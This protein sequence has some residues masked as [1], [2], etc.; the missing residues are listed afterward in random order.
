MKLQL[1][2][3]ND[4]FSDPKYQTEECRQLL[5]IYKDYY[6]KKGFQPP[7]VAYLILNDKN[8]MG[9]CSFTE[10]PINGAVEIAYWTFK[11]FEGKGVAS[12]A[13]ESLIHIAEKADPNVLL[14]AKTAPE[15]NASTRILEKNG[16][17]FSGVVQDDEIGDAWLWKKNN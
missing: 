7:W 14:T 9:T 15:H 13:C 2:N 5:E 1:L 11:P 8:V 10:K 6:S 12:F 3:L 17:S 4:D 16:F